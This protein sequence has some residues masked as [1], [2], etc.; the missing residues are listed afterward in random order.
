M[1]GAEEMRDSGPLAGGLLGL[2]RG[3]ARDEMCLVPSKPWQEG[4]E[5]EKTGVPL[6]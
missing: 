6:E 4:G 2:H 5:K 3:R 1:K